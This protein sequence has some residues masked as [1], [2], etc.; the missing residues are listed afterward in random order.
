MCRGADSAA[1]LRR[2]GQPS[3]RAC[4]PPTLPQTPTWTPL[5]LSTRT[6]DPQATRVMKHP[7]HALAAAFEKDSAD[8][9]YANRRPPAAV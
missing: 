6:T 9:E 8:V 2:Q 7:L 1:T 5:T 3:T 4:H